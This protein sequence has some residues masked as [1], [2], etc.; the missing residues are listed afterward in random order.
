MF[1]FVA[2]TA[3]AQTVFVSASSGNDAFDG[4]SAN[5]Q[6]GLVGPKLT[7]AAGIA[8][9]GA[10]GTISIEAGT[11]AEDV[12]VTTDLTILTTASG[13]NTTVTIGTGGGN[14][15]VL[16]NDTN[17]DINITGGGAVIRPTG[18]EGIVF[19]HGDVVLSAGALSI[20]ANAPVTVTDARV[21]G[22]AP[23]FGG[24][25]PFTYNGTT[26]S[27]RTVGVEFPSAV[28]LLTIS[29]TEPITFP[30]GFSA[31][32]ITHTSAGSGDVTFQGNVTSSALVQ[33]TGAGDMTFSGMLTSTFAGAPSVSVAD[34][35]FTAANVMLDDLGRFDVAAGETASISGT[36]T[37]QSDVD[38]GDFTRI[39]N[40]GTLTIGALVLTNND[41][42]VGVASGTNV[43]IHT[44][45][46]DGS[47]TIAS[48]SEDLDQSTTAGAAATDR[49]SAIFAL[50][51]NTGTS[52]TTFSSAVTISGTV[53]N[54]IAAPNGVYFNGGGTL[55]GDLNNAGG[56][57]IGTGMTLDLTSDAAAFTQVGDV[58]GSGTLLISGDANVPGTGIDADGNVTV[59]GASDNGGTTTVDGVFT[60]TGADADFTGAVVVGG[61]MSVKSEGSDFA[62]AVT[63]GGNLELDADAN[64]GDGPDFG[65][66][67]SV[68]GLL[69]VSDDTDVAGN[70]TAGNATVNGN[71]ALNLTSGGGTH[72]VSGT[73][74]VSGSSSVVLTAGAS[75]ITADMTTIDENALVDLNAGNT[76]V[77]Q[78]NFTGGMFDG[79]GAGATLRFDLPAAGASFSPGPNTQVTDFRVQGN[80]RTLTLLQSFEVQNDF[81]VADDATMSL[82]NRLVRMTGVADGTGLV[83]IATDASITA[84]DISGAIS[85]EGA[86]GALFTISSDVGGQDI[87]TL[88]NLVV[89]SAAVGP[90]AKVTVDEDV[91]VTGVINLVEGGITVT[92]GDT[93]TFTG[94][95]A[96]ISVNVGG[97][98]TA[99]TGTTAGIYDLTYTGVGPAANGAEFVDPGTNVIDDLTIST[100]GG[101]MTLN[102]AVGINGN[103]TVGSASIATI[104]GGLTVGGA[105]TVNAVTATD[106]TVNGAGTV[107]LGGAGM[108]HTVNGTVLAPLVFAA[109]ATV[110]GNASNNVE[111]NISNATINASQTVTISGLQ[112]I[113]GDL[114]VNGTLS[115]GLTD[116]DGA[117]A[118]DQDIE[119]DV[120]IDESGSLTLTSNVS[121]AGGG[122]LGTG[123]FAVGNGG[124]G[125]AALD[126]GGNTLTLSA[127]ASTFSADSDATIGTA[128]TIRVAAAT[129]IGSDNTASGTARAMLPT[130]NIDAVGASLT[131]D[132][133]VA[134]TLD[135]DEDFAIGAFDIWLSGDATFV[136]TSGNAQLDITGTTG[137]FITLGTTLT[138]AEDVS[139]PNFRLQSTG[140]TTLAENGAAA[141]YD[142]HVLNAGASTGTTVFQTGTLDLGGQDFVISDLDGTD[143]S[144]IDY[145]GGTITGSGRL[146]IE[147]DNDGNG[148]VDTDTASEMA[149][150]NLRVQVGAADAVAGD[151]NDGLD[152]SASD[153]ISVSG[154]LELDGGTIFIDNGATNDGTFTVG[155]GARIIRD[156]GVFDATAG[157]VGP[158]FGG[159][160]ISV[161]Y[162]DVVVTGRELPGTVAEL[163]IDAAITMADD[164][165]L[166]L[167]TLDINAAGSNLDVDADNGTVWTITDG[168]VVQLNHGAAAPFTAGGGAAGSDDG[169]ISYAGAYS[170]LFDGSSTSSAQVWQGSPSSVTVSGPGAVILTLGSAHTAAD[171]TVGAGETLAMGANNLTVT[172]NL[173]QTG[174]VTSAGG[175]LAFAGTTA[176]TF[177]LPA[178]GNTLPNVTFN[179]AAGVDLSG[180]NLNVATLA[181]F[182]SG[183]VRTGATN[184]IV[185][186]HTST[187]VQGFAQTSGGV[188][189]NVRK[190]IVGGAL[191]SAADRM[192]FPAAAADGTSRPVSI[193]FNQPNQIGAATVGASGIAG[194]GASTGISLTVN[195]VETSPGGN[196]NLPLTTVDNLGNDL[197]IARY[198]DFHWLITSSSTLSPSVDYDI[199]LNAAGYAAFSG[200]D[201]ERTR[202]IRRQGGASTNFWFLVG[203][204]VAANN[205]NFANSATNPVTVVRN[206]VGAL[207]SG[208]G[209]LF[210]MGLESNMAVTNPAAVAVNAGS[211]ATVD[212][213]TVFTGGTGAYTYA[214]TSGDAAVATGAAAANT[215]TVTGVAAGT[216]TVTVVATDALNDTRTA[217]VAVTVNPALAAG[218]IDAVAINAGGTSTVDLSTVFTGGASPVTYV[219]TS[220][221]AAAATGAEA[222]GT[223]TITAVAAGSATITVTATDATSQTATA[224]VAV[225]VN[226]AMSATNPA[227]LTLTEGAS[228]D[229]DLSTV[230]AGGNGTYTYAVS[231]A[232][233]NVTA[234]VATG[235]LTVTAAEA[236][237]AGTTIGTVDVTVTATDGLGSSVTAT[238]TVDVLPVLGDLDGSGSPSAASAS[239]ALDYFLGL[240]TLTAKQQV[241]ADF[242]MDGSVNAFDAALI[243]NAFL[244]GKDELNANVAASLQ[245]GTIEHAEGMIN[246]PL[247]IAGDLNEVVAA[248]FTA[249][250]DPT[251]AKVVA[252]N[253]D[254]DGE[255]IV[256]HTVS[257]EG[258]LRIA[259]AGLGTIPTEGTIATISVQLT[260]AGAAFDLVA[261]GSVNNNS[262]SALDAVEV[263]ELP[264]SFTLQGNYPNPFNPTTTIQFDLPQS[265]DVEVQVIDMVGRM[266]MT[267]PAQNMSAG[268]NRSVQLNASQL[269]SGSYFYRVI[270]RMESKTFVET[271]RMLL[272]K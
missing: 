134:G 153:I 43:D 22:T 223:L 202:T 180:G 192:T 216:T 244:N 261:D 200:E 87:G 41:T 1:A 91:A 113:L 249:N 211:A 257:E 107:T 235:T 195:H 131:S 262:T 189:G 72:N 13:A 49:I 169:E 227:T 161:E 233:A 255:W 241:A 242:N 232:A 124:P 46:N 271:G 174:A 193:T 151:A 251:K 231:S 71:E 44:I 259:V 194:F 38:N 168:G 149:L 215:L 222:S 58:N 66:A 240:T 226:A 176:Q 237:T 177:T 28:S 68:T 199:E 79:T 85:F 238:V 190:F 150:T 61:N 93:M 98:N 214:V 5:V 243:F 207:N 171:V 94:N 47:L 182:T 267:L 253:S 84:T 8:A 67:V 86:A 172:G 138:M 250:I 254:L 45:A 210:T 205:D 56:I 25:V 120:L 108:T 178:A 9:A 110:N 173:T 53:Q 212:L 139:V 117:G 30:G 60:V 123:G 105:M 204:G 50:T 166:T 103:F 133:G 104:V 270:A 263:V 266:V 95:S 206:A 127:A 203:G 184:A 17:D 218:T 229:I 99:I 75:T 109:N 32:G 258:Q 11:Y 125:S 170:L 163:Q 128:G 256:K 33:T 201:I 272:L 37:L 52:R 78:G 122:A 118:D 135:F 156:F 230:F 106:G 65:G 70:L 220:S 269:A 162:D 82:T 27:A 62:A 63:V 183:N 165:D 219:V 4:T 97:N 185:L 54:A 132:L 100:T 175:T 187:G 221:D 181:T 265:A 36:L 126:L 14:A 130:V 143:E 40:N 69:T 252:V 136:D 77:S 34:G 19:Q 115:L 146:V 114:I 154:T 142:F 80:E 21:T 158:V 245:F 102:P 196:N 31:S 148:G 76:F 35:L 90:A 92:G 121:V 12:T 268:T 208:N 239:I 228:S 144:L 18:I 157:T 112:E 129:T 111:S 160:T 141:S 64:G 42:T 89:S 29:T 26:T 147:D 198:P 3:S 51:N 6:S 96:G 164:A 81:F 213:S 264:D 48:V 24:A 197:T 74:T 145:N 39:D 246:I 179:N 59:T 88:T 188:V 23:V 191:G 7:I 137:R 73:L 225:T 2:T 140:T 155:D 152:M 10:G 217:T 236:Y 16:G 15:L 167:T 224:T 248:S 20:P 55:N 57:V 247:L 186:N 260:D 234:A 83:E 159:N 119:G 116:A 101:A 209:V